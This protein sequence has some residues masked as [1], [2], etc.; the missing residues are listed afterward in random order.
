MPSEDTQF[1]KSANP[2]RAGL[3]FENEEV[4]KT[5]IGFRPYVHDVERMSELK[6]RSGFI[7]KAV[8]SALDAAGL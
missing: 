8:R 6:D 1:S 3:E 5:P 4:S 2:Q 7:R